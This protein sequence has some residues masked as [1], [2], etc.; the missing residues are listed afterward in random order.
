[1]FHPL[2]FGIF[3]TIF[4]TL[5]SW[6]THAKA[7]KILNQKLG[8]NIKMVYKDDK[9]E[10][11][12]IYAENKKLIPIWIRILNLLSPALILSGG[13]LIFFYLYYH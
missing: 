7:F 11:A 13:G 1:M 2:V 9:V 6:L 12:K 5:I 10:I 8:T 4:F 3:L